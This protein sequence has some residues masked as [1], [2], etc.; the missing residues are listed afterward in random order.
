MNKIVPPYFLSMLLISKLAFSTENEG[1]MPQLKPESF[2]SQVFWLIL[3]FTIL[4]LII[5]F[6]FLPKLNEIRGKR[7]K[8]IDVPLSI[9]EPVLGGYPNQA[10]TKNKQDS[11]ENL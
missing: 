1:G 5:H 11:R 2:S 6:Y 8:T 3:L 10:T 4:F 7:E 9:T